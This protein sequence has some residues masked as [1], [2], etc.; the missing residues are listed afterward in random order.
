MRPAA[1][2][3]V[4]GIVGLAACAWWPLSPALAPQDAL[5]ARLVCAAMTAVACTAIALVKG[6]RSIV[7]T[8]L[9]IA[10][11]AAAVAMLLLYFRAATSCVADYNGRPTIIGRSYTAEGRQYVQDNPASSNATLLLDAGGDATAVWTPE[12]ILQ[13][14]FWVSWGALLPIPLFAACVGCLVTSRRW[15]LSAKAGREPAVAGPRTSDR[16]ATTFDAFISYR[17][18]DPDRAHAHDLVEALESRGLRVAIDA[19]DFAPNEHFIAEM[20]RAIH[21]SRFV[22]CVITPRYVDSDH[23]VEEAVMCK[24]LDL[25]ERRK[26]L[27]PLIFERVELPVWLHGLVG[28]DFSEAAAVDP[29]ERLLALMKSQPA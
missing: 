26:R 22:L 16:G 20:E 6:G 2:I 24:T 27:V 13:C 23:C 25:G 17:H 28:V 8:A 29:L 14:R 1:W 9:S 15:R 7:W 4:V 3:G 5:Q 11:A 18:V 21:T 19:R 12:S 10:S